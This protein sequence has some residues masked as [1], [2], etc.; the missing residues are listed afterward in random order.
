MIESRAIIESIDRTRRSVEKLLAQFK[1]NYA[2]K[3]II[4]IPRKKNENYNLNEDLIRMRIYTKNN[5]PTKKVVLVRKKT[6]WRKDGKKSNITIKK[7]FDNEKE[8][9]LFLTQ[10]FPGFKKGF[11]YFREGWQY[12]FNGCGIFVE[13]IA[14]LPPSV[15]IEAT[16]KKKLQ[17][18]FKKL[19]VKKVLRDSIPKM[20]YK[21][22]K[23]II[24]N[25][26]RW[27]PRTL[28]TAGIPLPF[29]SP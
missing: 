27:S 22:N 1:G 28:C 29:P 8:A 18:I 6:K 13:N 10:N 15:E 20:I 12:G 4:F 26:L 24:P 19:G 7:E 3:D 17:I 2:F 11:E 16:E 5:W 9:L 21:K 14:G 23:T 25:C